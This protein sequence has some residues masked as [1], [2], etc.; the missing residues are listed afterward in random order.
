M[1]I[2][3]QHGLMCLMCDGC[4]EDLEFFEANEFNVMIADAKS[5]GWRIRKDD[6]GDWEHHCP[7]C[8]GNRVADARRMFGL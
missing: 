2:E 7:S 8:Q 4:D 5:K 3:R 6:D 1:T